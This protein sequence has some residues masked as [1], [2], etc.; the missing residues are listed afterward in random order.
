M[1]NILAYNAS[2]CTRVQH[3]ALHYIIL[4]WYC[5]DIHMTTYWSRCLNSLT[6]NAHVILCYIDTTGI[7]IGLDSICLNG[8]AH[9]APQMHSSTSWRWEAAET[10]WKLP[11]RCIVVLQCVYIVF[12][13]VFH[14][15]ELCWQS[16]SC[17]WWLL[18]WRAGNQLLSLRTILASD[19]YLRPSICWIFWAYNIP[20]ILN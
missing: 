3:D 18:P 8:L 4:Y 5:I 15:F 13:L 11:M 6:Q 12:S 2:W 7:K 16:G 9:N 20:R 19:K 1:L 17:P 14:C 10:V